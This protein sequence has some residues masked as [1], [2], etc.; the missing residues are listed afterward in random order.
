MPILTAD[1]IVTQKHKRN[2]IQFGEAREATGGLP[3]GMRSTQAIQGVSLPSRAASARSG[4]PT[5]AGSAVTR[6][7]GGGRRR[8]WPAPLLLPTAYGAQIP[9]Q[10][11]K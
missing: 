1:Q 10:L 3:A 8:I 5:R 6:W 9:R 7:S 11:G 4:C 2:F